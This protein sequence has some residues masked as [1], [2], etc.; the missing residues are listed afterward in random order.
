M[1]ETYFNS[2]LNQCLFV[3]HK[4]KKMYK[5]ILNKNKFSPKNKF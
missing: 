1:L 4:N 2:G 5:N 3:M